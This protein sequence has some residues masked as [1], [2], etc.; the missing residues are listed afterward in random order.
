MIHN[1]TDGSRL[2]R[3]EANTLHSNGRSGTYSL[4]D[5]FPKNTDQQVSTNG[6]ISDMSRC[7]EFTDAGDDVLQPALSYIMT[8]A[9]T[10]ISIPKNN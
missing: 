5:N 8:M 7:N 10:H 6:Y 3:W 9:I 1:V 4:T 2:G